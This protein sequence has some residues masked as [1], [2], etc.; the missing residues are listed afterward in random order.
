MG[1]DNNVDVD[2]GEGIKR[3]MLIMNFGQYYEESV[4]SRFELLPFLRVS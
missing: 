3:P 2:V 1:V 4:T